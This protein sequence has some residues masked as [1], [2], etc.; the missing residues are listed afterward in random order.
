MRTIY[1]ILVTLLVAS[2]A[3]GQITES[4]IAHLSRAEGIFY[5]GAG[6]GRCTTLQTT[7]NG[8]S[9][10]SADDYAAMR[11]LLSL[12]TTNTP[13]FAELGLGNVPVTGW[14]LTCYQSADSQGL[15][16]FGYDDQAANSVAIM[17][18]PG[19]FGKITS[20]SQLMLGPVKGGLNYIYFT[21]SG[22]YVTGSHL[23]FQ[24]NTKGVRFGG[25]LASSI[26][27]DASNL[28]LTDPTTG[29]KTLAQ[30]AADTDTLGSI[31]SVANGDVLIYNSG[32]KRLGK[33]DDGQVLKLA[34]GLPAWAADNNTTYTGGDGL[35]LT[36]TDFDLDL[37]TGGGL[38][39]DTG[40]LRLSTHEAAATQAGSGA[41]A[42]L[43]FSANA[44]IKFTFDNNGGATT[45]TF[46]DPPAGSRCL[47]IL[48]QD[49]D[50]GET[51]TWPVAET[52]YWAGGIA[53]DPDTTAASRAVVTLVFD[54][55]DY[56]CTGYDYATAP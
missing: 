47:L 5:M 40:R 2:T 39:I 31:G 53:F 36:E 15:K 44:I 18:D 46:T 30:L 13:Q 56:Y 41:T 16:I 29:S 4:P 50:G 11:T 26:F 51:V 45:F 42:T 28:Q 27:S 1:S 8:R 17:V 12:A 32:W 14:P 52:I 38:E 19:G 43:D 48:I 24:S 34:T 54:G 22:I 9:L 33:G 3:V 23:D 20:S 21:N 49:A 35:T 7:A 55:T 37:K 25:S 6:N 10:I